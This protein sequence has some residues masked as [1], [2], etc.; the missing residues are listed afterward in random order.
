MIE[1]DAIKL[2]LISEKIEEAWRVSWKMFFREETFLF[3]NYLTIYDPAKCLN[4]LPTQAEVVACMPN[5]CGWGTGMEDSM[6]N[7]GTIISMIC[8]RFEVTKDEAMRQ[9]ATDVFK[10][11]VSCAEVHGVKGFIARSVCLFDGKS[12]YADS[13]RDHGVDMSISGE[14]G[15]S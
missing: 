3:Y 4:H 7:A 12:V 1:E 5:P 15:H 13:S 10:G 2:E 14:V 8:D 6:I 9:Y 11:M